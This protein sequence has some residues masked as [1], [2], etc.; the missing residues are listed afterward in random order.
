M[1]TTNYSSLSE[2]TKREAIL[3]SLRGRMISYIGS[4]LLAGL[5]L[6]LM[7]WFMIHITNTFF[8]DSYTARDITKFSVIGFLMFVVFF[9][10]ETLNFFLIRK[11]REHHIINPLWFISQPTSQEIDHYLKHQKEEEL[12]NEIKSL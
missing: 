2:E 12:D 5:S 1:N 10:L 11:E 8:P 9:G 4:L 7:F 3:F 6:F